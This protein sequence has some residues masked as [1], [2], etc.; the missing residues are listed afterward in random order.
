MPTQNLTSTYG[1]GLTHDTWIL[2]AGGSKAAALATND[3]DSTYVRT[4]GT[5]GQ[6]MKF[7]DWPTG[8]GLV[9]D[10]RSRAYA[11]YEAGSK[12]V[13]IGVETSAGNTT[14]LFGL[15][16][17]YVLK[18]TGSLAKPGGGS[19]EASDAAR[20][21]TWFHMTANADG[22][23]GVRVTQAY[24]WIDYT[25]AGEAF[26]SFWSFLGPL[27]GASLTLSQFRSALELVARAHP[28]ILSFSEVDVRE[29]WRAFRSWR[30]PCYSI[31]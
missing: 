17:G 27:L 23:N 16:T 1:S 24:L 7:D 29:Y 15:S 6:D 4:I 3:G 11:K 19:W 31:G 12:N 21:A 30:R 14:T 25:Q 18:A 5:S 9:N 8:V 10:V 22:S 20:D 13:S 26:L 28:S 2:G